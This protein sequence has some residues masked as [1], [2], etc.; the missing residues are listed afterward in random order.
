MWEPTGEKIDL[1]EREDKEGEDEEKQVK[2][3][4]DTSRA[5]FLL[6]CL[7]AREVLFDNVMLREDNA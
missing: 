4:L 2:G 3:E 1:E 5:L 6:F 7:V